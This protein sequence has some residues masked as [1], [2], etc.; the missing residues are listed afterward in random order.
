MPIF[1]FVSYVP[2]PSLK[3]FFFN[4]EKLVWSIMVETFINVNDDK[5]KQFT[6]NVVGYILISA[7][8]F[9]A[10]LVTC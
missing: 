10:A 8:P 4:I 1:F 3:A 6:R 9:L 2:S 7:L 5:L